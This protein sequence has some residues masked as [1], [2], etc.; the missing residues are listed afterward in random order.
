MNDDNTTQDYV[1]TTHSNYI[2]FDT[3]KPRNTQIQRLKY[4]CVNFR[5]RAVSICSGIVERAGDP[6]TTSAKVSQ[7]VETRT[8]S[9]HAADDSRALTFACFLTEQR[10]RDYLL[11]KIHVQDIS[12]FVSV[13][14]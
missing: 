4:L 5:L 12:G 8:L 13:C 3:S 11:S 6:R 7:R 1:T 9:F 10:G 2:S 14:S